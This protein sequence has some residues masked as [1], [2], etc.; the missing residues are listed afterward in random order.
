MNKINHISK[1][2]NSLL[3]LY[4]TLPDSE[5]SSWHRAKSQTLTVVSSEQEQNF[6]SVL[7]K[8]FKDSHYTMFPGGDKQKY[9]DNRP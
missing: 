4:I 2:I 3:I 7:Q 1:T 9:R 6:K 8:L 5:R